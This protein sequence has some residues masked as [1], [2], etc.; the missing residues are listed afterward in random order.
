MS[1]RKQKFCS[2]CSTT[3]DVSCFSKNRNRPD[4]KDHYCIACKSVIDAKRYRKKRASQIRYARSW[5]IKNPERARNNILQRTYGISLE[6]YKE[7]DTRQKGRCAICGTKP[8][9]RLHVDHCHETKIVRGLLCRQ[10]NTALGFL[11]HSVRQVESAARYLRK[12]NKSKPPQTHGLLVQE[13]VSTNDD[14]YRFD[15]SES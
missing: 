12:F 4:G 15:I 3:K 9:D 14:Q 7:M 5:K 8:K 11:N 2:G 13:F 1:P 10:C 6:Q